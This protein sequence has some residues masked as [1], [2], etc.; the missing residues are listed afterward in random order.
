MINKKNQFAIILNTLF[1]KKI[2]STS[3]EMSVL[4]TDCLNFLINGVVYRFKPRTHFG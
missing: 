4:K 2:P 1:S 3:K